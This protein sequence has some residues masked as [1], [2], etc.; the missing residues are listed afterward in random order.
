MLWVP[1]LGDLCDSLGD[2]TPTQLMESHFLQLLAYTVPVSFRK[3][4][5]HVIAEG[6]YLR[7]VGA[8]K[9]TVTTFYIGS[10]FFMV[11]IGCGFLNGFSFWPQWKVQII[12]KPVL[13][14]PYVG[15]A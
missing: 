15:L 13:N 4:P 3:S 7:I 8:E 6:Q 14:I 9:T 12:C 2:R 11:E 10:Q 1:L 5:T